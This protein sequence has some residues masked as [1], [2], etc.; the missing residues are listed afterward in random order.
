MLF[1]SKKCEQANIGKKVYLNLF[2]H[3]GAT[4][5]ATFM[6]EAQMKLRH[7]WTNQSKMPSRYV[8]LVQSDVEKT[9]LER[10]GLIPKDKT[11]TQ[12]FRHCPACKQRNNSDVEF[13]ENCAKPLSLEKALEIDEEAKKEKETLNKKIE[14]MEKSQEEKTDR[15]KHLEEQMSV[16]LHT[17]NLVKTTSPADTKTDTTLRD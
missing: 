16:I 13:C 2:R 14:E 4:R 1:R 9:I 11:R 10:Y 8:H 12:M 6:T 17:L 3:S 7:G 15:I 5:A